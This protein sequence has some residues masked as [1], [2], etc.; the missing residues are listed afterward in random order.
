MTEPHTDIV[1]GHG[2]VATLMIARV[3]DAICRLLEEEERTDITL[4]ELRELSRDAYERAG[5]IEERR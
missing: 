1:R 2:S 3:T 4:A 5:P